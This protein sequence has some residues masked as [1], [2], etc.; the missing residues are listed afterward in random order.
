MNECSTFLACSKGFTTIRTIVRN[1]RSTNYSPLPKYRL[2]S[3]FCSCWAKN[4]FYIL[5]DRKKNWKNNI[6]K[7]EKSSTVQ[8]PASTPEVMRT[9]K[10]CGMVCSL[11]VFYTTIAEFRRDTVQSGKSRIFPSALSSKCL[12]GHALNNANK[13]GRDGIHLDTSLDEDRKR[14]T[15]RIKRDSLYSQCLTSF[16]VSG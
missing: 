2:L 10:Q 7:C 16:L 11:W 5:S 15:G 14:E 6:S 8:I 1:Q 3:I 4:I 13:G 9:Q 12:P